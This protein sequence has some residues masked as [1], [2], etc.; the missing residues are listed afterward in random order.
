MSDAVS[1]I[2]SMGAKESITDKVFIKFIYNMLTANIRVGSNLQSWEF[3]LSIIRSFDLL[4]FDLSIFWIF[5][6]D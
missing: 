5:K 2:K 4:I 6:K 3:D 1:P